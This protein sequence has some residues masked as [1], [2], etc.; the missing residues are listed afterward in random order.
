MIHMCHCCACLLWVCVCSQ[1]QIVVIKELDYEISNG[2]YVLTVT[3]TDQ[4]PIPQFRR[5]SS[6]TVLVNV[7]DV[8]DNAPIFPRPFEGPLEITEGQPG[9]RVWTVKA[10]DDDSGSNGKVEYSITAGDLKSVCVW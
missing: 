10:T 6:T 8:N 9:P 5:T 1:G 7:V 2:H 4:C 3:A